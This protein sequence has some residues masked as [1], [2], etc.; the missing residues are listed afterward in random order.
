MENGLVA[1][2][3]RLLNLCAD[4]LRRLV[5]H[6]LAKIDRVSYGILGP[7]DMLDPRMPTSRKLM[8]VQQA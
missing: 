6:V 4:W 7:L 2:S 1:E 3:K 8:A 5:P